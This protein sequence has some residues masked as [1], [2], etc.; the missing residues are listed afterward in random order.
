VRAVL[1]SIFIKQRL[2]FFISSES[3][4][5]IDPLVEM[6][7]NG[8]VIAA[9]GQRSTLV[10]APDAIRVIE[11]GGAVGKTVIDVSASGG[12]R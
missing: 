10:D 3:R 7:A 12:D 4:T 1:W 8:Q 6:L 5:Y 9:I 11:R 2:T